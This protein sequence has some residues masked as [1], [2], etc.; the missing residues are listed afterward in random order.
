MRLALAVIATALA[1]ATPAAAVVPEVSSFEH[2]G[3]AVSG[4]LEGGEGEF[5]VAVEAFLLEVDGQPVVNVAADAIFGDVECLTNEGSSTATFADD[6][7][8]ATLTGSVTG[9]C[10]DFA[11]EKESS[12]S[13][14]FDLTWT[15]VGRLERRAFGMRLDGTVCS[16]MVVSREAVATGTLTWSAPQLGIGG[17]GSPF[18]RAGI[19]RFTDRCITT[20]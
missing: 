9:S 7:S 18:G 3:A 12:Y 1:T 2:V 20:G 19:E 17:T 4:P 13:A 16:T 11:Q 8:S 10:F 6:L 14:E 15:A 5:F